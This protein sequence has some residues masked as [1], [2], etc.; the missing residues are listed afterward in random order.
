MVKTELT[1]IPATLIPGDGIGPEITAAVVD[2]LEALSAPFDW[3][4]QQGGM[5]AIEAGGDPGL[6]CCVKARAHTTGGNS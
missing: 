4:Q 1:R 3:D 6:T 2:I 5:A